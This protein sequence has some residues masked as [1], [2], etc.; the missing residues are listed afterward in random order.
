[1]LI[2]IQ[3]LLV[4]VGIGELVCFILVLMKMFQS[5]EQTMGI[6]CIVLALCCGIGGLVAFVYGWINV[7]KW[8]LK[9]IMW[10]WTGLFIATIVLY[11]IAM[12]SGASMIP[13]MGNFKP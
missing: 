1:M 3:G 9:N 11:A 10:I 2:L 8:D 7:T 12:V 6:V 5:G 13:Q 4:L